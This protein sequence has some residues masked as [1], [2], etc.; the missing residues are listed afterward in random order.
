MP[1]VDG[2]TSTKMIRSMEQSSDHAGHSPLAAANGRVPVV[3]VSASLVEREKD[4]YVDAGF[5]AWILKPI[6]FRRLN[7]LMLGIFDEN[8]RN[9]CLY[10][11]GE[12]EQGGWF[13]SRS[14]TKV[15]VAKSGTAKTGGANDESSASGASV[16]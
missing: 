14:D 13:R 7:T 4:M 6:D 16:C 1:I 3:A 10:V 9:E 15:E 5:D 11:P 8:I 12:W 2:L